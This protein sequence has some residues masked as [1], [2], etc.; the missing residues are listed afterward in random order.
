M[1]IGWS[2]ICGPEFRACAKLGAIG[3]HP[4]LLPKLR[5]RAA[6]A[7]TIILQVHR[8]GS[9]LFWLSDGVDDGDI[10]AQEAF[11]LDPGADLPTLMGLHMET[12]ARMLPPLVRQLAT[13]VRPARPQRHEEA[14]CLAI[15]RPADGE[16][17]WSRGAAEIERLVRATTQPYPGAFTFWRGRKVTIWSARVV[18]YP[19]WTAL[20]G[21]VFQYENGVA[22]VRCGDG[23]DLALTNYE[24]EPETS[25]GARASTRI[26]GQPRLGRKL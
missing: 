10:A 3:Y 25:P 17:D 23:G 22:I 15:R 6:L 13:G 1:V 7:W 2:R 9:T 26:S 18:S 14:T 16:I 4:T 19:Q 12:L 24:V 5:G 11:D 20:P 8:T 21:Q